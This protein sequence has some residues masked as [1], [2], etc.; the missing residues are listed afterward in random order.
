MS[1]E[2]LKNYYKILNINKNASKEEVKSAYRKLAKVM[3][4]DVNK[5]SDAKEKFQELA[6]AYEILYNDSSRKAY[7]DLIRSCMQK[8]PSAREKYQ[9]F[10]QNEQR[11][12]REQA[13]KYY[14]MSLDEVLTAAT[15]TLLHGAKAG[16]AELNVKV[17]HILGF[18]VM[19]CWGLI[20]LMGTVILTIPAIVLISYVIKGFF[21]NGKFVGIIPV[22]KGFLL[23][24]A[25]LLVI[26]M[27][28]ILIQIRLGV[29]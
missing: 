2:V 9:N 6:E 11:K 20:S 27:I 23:V 24:F 19:L 26:C 4:P 17:Y 14:Y 8:S 29:L 7:D 1:D 3:H 25:E 5:A 12:A 15:K 18:R 28:I 10:R 16:Q 22:I 13:Q 21:Y